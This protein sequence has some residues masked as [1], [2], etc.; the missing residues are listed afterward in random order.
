MMRKV[1]CPGCGKPLTKKSSKGRYYC[2]ND[3]CP[4]IYVQRPYN[5]AIRKI[6]Y[7]PSASENAIRKIEKT[8]A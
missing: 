5:F 4:V 2:E 7:K 1:D 3:C 6:V 8:P